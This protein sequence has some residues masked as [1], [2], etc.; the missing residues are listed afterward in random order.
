MI[1]KVA[2]LG[3]IAGWVYLPKGATGDPRPFAQT[4]AAGSAKNRESVIGTKYHHTKP[5][6]VIQRQRRKKAHP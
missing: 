3:I 6:P 2:A 4:W 5:R 1:G